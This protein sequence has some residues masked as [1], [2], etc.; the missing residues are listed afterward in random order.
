MFP[1]VI[2]LMMMSDETA[3]RVTLT[4]HTIVAERD[5]DRVI[6]VSFATGSPVS[7]SVRRMIRQAFGKRR[8]TKPKPETHAPQPLLSVVPDSEN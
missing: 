7:K 4:E 2:N 3:T 1:V 6:A 5:G 8:V